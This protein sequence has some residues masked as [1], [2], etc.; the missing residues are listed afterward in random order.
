[1]GALEIDLV[2]E[3]TMNVMGKAQINE[4]NQLTFLNPIKNTYSIYNENKNKIAEVFLNI[5]LEALNDQNSELSG[6]TSD[7]GTDYSRSNSL[8][9][10]NRNQMTKIDDYVN[11]NQY[12]V[13]NSNTLT[14]ATTDSNNGAGGPIGTSL[15]TTLLDKGK[16]LKEEMIKSTLNTK[17]HTMPTSFDTLLLPT[18]TSTSVSTAAARTIA[19]TSTINPF[20]NY[21]DSNSRKFIADDNINSRIIN[22]L[23]D[24]QKSSVINESIIANEL[25]LTPNYE[26]DSNDSDLNDPLH[27]ANI[28]NN[29][30][31]SN[32][33]AVDDAQDIDRF[34]QRRSNLAHQAFH[35][36]RSRSR[37]PKNKKIR[38]K[39]DESVSSSHSR[40][41]S[42][43]ATHHQLPPLSN[44]QSLIKTSSPLVSHTKPSLTSLRKKKRDLNQSGNDSDQSDQSRVSFDMQHSD[45]EQSFDS[46]SHHQGHNSNTLSVER[47]NL[48]G[49]IQVAKVNIEKIYLILNMQ[50]II[51]SLN[52]KT[53]L[54]VEKSSGKPPKSSLSNKQIA[55]FIEYQFPVVASSRDQIGNATMA[56]E[57]MRVASKRVDFVNN[58]IH[59]THSATFP[60]LFNGNSLELWWK[61]ILVFKIY[62][63]LPTMKAPLLIGAS[64][65]ALKDLLKAENLKF[66]KKLRL[67]DSSNMQQKATNKQSSLS[68][69]SIDCKLELSSNTRDF[70]EQLMKLRIY[71]ANNPKNIPIVATANSNNNN[72]S[73]KLIL[74]STTGTSTKTNSN[75]KS[76]TNTNI[77][78]TINSSSQTAIQ[79]YL[80]INEGRN[81]IFENSIAT[82][83][84][85]QTKQQQQQQQNVE[86][87]AKNLYLISRLFWCDE[88]LKSEICWGINKQQ[89]GN[90]RL[91][92]FNLKESLT[93]FLNKNILERMHNNYMIVE[94][95]NKRLKAQQTDNLIGI[96]KLPLN[97]FYIQFK[98][99]RLIKLFYIKSKQPSIGC[100]TWM[101]V[102]DPFSGQKTGELNILLAMGSTDQIFNLQNYKLDLIEINENNNNNSS[103][104]AKAEK[105]QNEHLFEVK[106]DSINNLKFF[107]N[108]V[109]GE[110]D[111]YVQ[112][113]F[114]TQTNGVLSMKSYRTQTTL[115]IPNLSFNEILKHSIKTS[116]NLF[117]IQKELLFAFGNS[118]GGGGGG[119][120]NT[121]NYNLQFEIWLR[122]Y[123]PNVRDQ[124]VAR[125]ELPLNKLCAMLSMNDAAE[126]LLKHQ[127]F[128]IK[129]YSITNHQVSSSSSSSSLVTTK[130]SS[131][132]LLECGELGIQIN[133]KIN[134]IKSNNNNNHHHVHNELTLSQIC[135]NVGIIRACGLKACAKYLKNTEPKLQYASEIGLN[136]YVK[137]HLEILN[138]SFSLMNQ[139]DVGKQTRTIARSFIPEYFH[140]FDFLCPI[141]WTNEESETISLAELLDNNCLELKFELWHQVPRNETT[142]SSGDVDVLIGTTNVK[143]K[144]LL[145][146]QTGIKGWLPVQS[147]IIGWKMKKYSSNEHNGLPNPL[148]YING[149]LEIN[150][151][152][153][154]QDDRSRI[155]DAAKQIGFNRYNDYQYLFNSLTLNDDSFE[156]C[157]LFHVSVEQIQIPLSLG[158][159][160]G[161]K[162]IHSTTKCYLRYKLFDSEP[163]LTKCKL[164]EKSINDVDLLKCTFK[165]SK[166]HV[167]NKSAQLLWYLNEEQ[168][169]IQLWLTND[170]EE[171]KTK[172]SEKD[173]L[174]GSAFVNMDSFNMDNLATAKSIKTKKFYRINGLYPLYKLAHT[175]L[176]GSFC[177]IN[178]T[179][180]KLNDITDTTHTSLFDGTRTFELYGDDSSSLATTNSFACIIG[181]ERASHLPLV[182]DR[183][184]NRHVDPNA[185]VTYSSAKTKHLS[186]TNIVEHTINPV[187]NYQETTLFSADHLFD[188]SKCL[189]LK[190]WH[191]INLDLEQ[192]T[193]EKS[194]DKVIG[195]V[196]IDLSPLMS[197]LQQISGW[198]NIIDLVGQCQGQLKVNICPQQNLFEFKRSFLSTKPK[199]TTSSQ[200]ES[201]FNNNKIEKHLSSIRMHHE[202]LRN[203]NSSDQNSSDSCLKTNLRKQL[204]DL[205]K[206]N[207]KLKEKLRFSNS[208]STTT[209]STIESL[210]NNSTASSN[211]V[212]VPT[213]SI[214]RKSHEQQQQQQTPIVE[215]NIQR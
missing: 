127:S 108:M 114:P 74:A 79:F 57:V 134:T 157:Y 64:N 30:F 43:G 154:Q 200:H 152:F 20:N 125:G 54:S 47:L 141:I 177:E 160:H 204:D 107:D 162:E 116:M 103:V 39:S 203:N 198:Y 187:W 149:G 207:E 155:L 167:F 174:V 51:D 2:D 124:I 49:Q 19:S 111:C 172:P 89:Y 202:Y 138:E 22:L 81:F 80:E 173:R 61:T 92:K 171:F 36:S 3:K 150:I 132:P 214:S 73:S 211:V 45:H 100:D 31:Y 101:P 196:S 37:S 7:T 159:R 13:N 5:K 44:K 12:F 84:Q 180:E 188:E 18:T 123:Y 24:N 62:A 6:F 46:T 144:Q 122:Y 65:V 184:L 178:L 28:I 133:Y 72:N 8:I 86:I 210:T 16:K 143:L 90:D 106:I 197:G 38:K 115:C 136:V 53:S 42:R 212:V 170:T 85:T 67:I 40:S 215:S 135:I 121:L 185:Y 175:D 182:H 55:Y 14:T 156:K 153:G 205:D 126:N 15:I 193:P 151:R 158:I 88:K 91:I 179:L 164:I 34:T 130:S 161:E 95:W 102:I 213:V 119:G 69:G 110:T 25:N 112:Y 71:E 194:G 137:V 63:R 208:P 109:W 146:K 26:Y 186:F 35:K 33:D 27:D 192:Q 165:F 195:F 129:L 60:V 201:F 96:V 148:N 56:T 209:A 139:I 176:S 94:V 206:I 4:I 189:I 97:Q 105:F 82:Q 52:S 10:T 32:Y 76:S 113:Y 66:E 48:L 58:E 77:N 98:D 169:E 29:L 23:V 120:G 190:V 118:G 145:Y 140:Y 9:N 199:A 166:Q 83:L 1:M 131:S 87:D 21:N 117:N 78:E 11:K 163:V 68:I 181:I 41:S 99:D 75:S 168:L 50:S 147:P 93:F 183:L 142:G 59:F 104:V 70:D 17:T 191:K 128:K